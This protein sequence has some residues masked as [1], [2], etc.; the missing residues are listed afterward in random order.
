MPFLKFSGARMRDARQAADMRA[1]ELAIEI[2]RSMY[3]VAQYEQGRITPPINVAAR[4]AGVLG[5]ALDD[6]LDEEVT[7]DVA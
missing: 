3:S 7:G 6:L 1:E 5:V 4:I 2:D